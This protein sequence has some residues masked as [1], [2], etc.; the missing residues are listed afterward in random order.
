VDE[1]EIKPLVRPFVRSNLA[2]HLTFS[3]MNQIQEALVTLATL[4]PEGAEQEAM[5]ARYREEGGVLEE[6]EGN[7]DES[8]DDS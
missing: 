3:R 5:Y 1:G 4:L 8:E 2:F 6:D 7:T